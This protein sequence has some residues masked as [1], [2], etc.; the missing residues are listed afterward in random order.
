MAMKAYVTSVGEPTTDLCVWALERNH[1]D[2][3]LI[4]DDTSLQQKLKKIYEMANEDFIRVDADVIVNKWCNQLNI[5][6]E[7]NKT[8]YCWWMQ[9]RCWGWYSQDLIYGGVQYIKKEALPA[10]REN[11]D[12]FK[13]IDRPET[14]LSR[15][16]EF[17]D[18]RRFL[19]SERVYGIHGYGIKEVK[20]VI[21][22][23]AL[24]GQSANYDWELVQRMNE[25]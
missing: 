5:E 3:V 23:K 14:Q 22:Q 20:P 16:A 8:P 1:F 19:S 25:L 21:K 7:I 12:R 24:R 9:F 6:R 10:L 13:E 18:P 15:I 2:V 11:V 4:K 17:Y